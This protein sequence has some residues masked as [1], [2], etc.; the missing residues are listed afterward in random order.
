MGVRMQAWGTV[1]VTM[2]TLMITTMDAKI[3][4]RCELAKKLEKA[5]LNGFQGYSVGDCETPIAPSP[6]HTPNHPLHSD[7][8]LGCHLSPPFQQGMI[9]QSD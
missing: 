8:G 5:G 3:Y 1:L 2:T 6:T 4:E 7:P 9:F